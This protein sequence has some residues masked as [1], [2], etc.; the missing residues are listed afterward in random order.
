MRKA[1]SRECAAG[2]SRQRRAGTAGRGGPARGESG[3]LARSSG[4]GA[5]T[6][7]PGTVHG[8]EGAIALP[9]RIVALTA[10][11]LVSA[12]LLSDGY[13]AAGPA[14]FVVAGTVLAL[15]AMLAARA[16]I[17]PDDEP[18]P[19][20][21]R[22]NRRSGESSQADFPAFR[23]ISSD[24]TWATVSQRHF[25][26]GIRTRLAQLLDTR[27]AQ[28]H[29]WTPRPSQNAPANWPAMTC[30]HSSTRHGHSPKTVN[31]PGLAWPSSPGLLPGWRNCDR[32]AN[33]QRTG[34]AE[35]C[36]RILA[37]VEQVIVGKR[38]PVR[39]V[40]IGILAAGHILIEDLLGWARRCSPGTFAGALGLRSPGSS[41]PRTC[42]PPT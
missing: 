36:T 31:A 39:M 2:R 4:T 11:T 33:G 35:L 28:R 13:L 8:V 5:G 21:V 14:G 25:D 17:S 24:V 41:S 27:L 10:L 30:G 6:G 15:L 18:P 26:H 22:D 19:R 37:E 20:A 40:L 32:P 7:A 23:E 34:T 42:C 29:S 9:H 38:E 12:V 1:R 16:M 3:P